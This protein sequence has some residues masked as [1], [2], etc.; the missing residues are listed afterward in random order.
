M[1]VDTASADASPGKLPEELEAQDADDGREDMAA[2]Q[3]PRLCQGA[4]GGAEDQHRR[5]PEG[6]DHQP[7]VRRT[8]QG[9][10]HQG[11]GTDPKKGPNPGPK[12]LGVGHPRRAALGGAAHLAQIAAQ[13]GV[14][15]VAGWGIRHGRGRPRSRVGRQSLADF[16]PRAVDRDQMKTTRCSAC[17]DLGLPGTG[18][19]RPM[20]TLPCISQRPRYGHPLFTTLPPFS[21][22]GRG[23]KYPHNILFINRRL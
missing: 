2:H 6:P 3:V 4:A 12:D 19:R 10:T 5:G 8:R 1:A 11:H 23:L 13:P 18:S 20:D 21:K 16:L 15:A 14:G 22:G 7:L 17:R 9:V